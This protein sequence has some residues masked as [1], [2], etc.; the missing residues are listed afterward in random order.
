MNHQ[1]HRSHCYNNYPFCV[2]VE[3]GCLFIEHYTGLAV[4]ITERPLDREVDVAEII[5]I[6]LI[7]LQCLR[8][9]GWCLPVL[10]LGQPFVHP[11]FAV[12]SPVSSSIGN[13]HGLFQ[14]L[15]RSLCLLLTH[16]KWITSLLL[17][18]LWFPRRWCWRY[19]SSRVLLSGVS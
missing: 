10:M 7:G 17:R 9:V 16:L 1:C 5:E 14:F 12:R 4:N 15:Q 13:K 11:K 19:W 3:R 2:R 8:T 18:S 6:L